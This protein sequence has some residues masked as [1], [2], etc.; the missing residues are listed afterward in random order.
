MHGTI[1]RLGPERGFGFIVSERK[2]FFFHRSALRGVDFEEPA[3]GTQVE[4]DVEGN[5]EGDRPR[6]HPRAVSIRLSDNAVEA[7]DNELLPPGK[8]A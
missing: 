4:F 8:V 6:E 2:E 1:D 5:A 3:P 7:T